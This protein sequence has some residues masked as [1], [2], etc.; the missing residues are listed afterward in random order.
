MGRVRSYIG[1][2]TNVSTG[3]LVKSVFAVR[4]F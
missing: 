1:S 4:V 3:I 2:V